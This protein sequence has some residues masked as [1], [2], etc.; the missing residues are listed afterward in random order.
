MARKFVS[1]ST[2]S[3]SVNVAP[4]NN[5]P[6]TI[7]HRFNSQSL[8]ANQN[9]LMVGPSSGSADNIGTGFD[10]ATGQA[11]FY[12]SD[13][14][15]SFDVN[16][17][18]PIIKLNRWYSIVFVGR[19]ASDRSGYIVDHATGVIYALSTTFPATLGGTANRIWLGGF[20]ST[21]GN[22]DAVISD[23]AMWSAALE[24]QEVLAYLKGSRAGSIRRAAL[25]ADWR[26]DGTSSPETDFSG[27]GN[28]LTLNGSPAAAANLNFG[29]VAQRYVYWANAPAA[30]G[31]VGSSTGAATVTGIGAAQDSS[32]GS[33]VGAATVTGVS[34]TLGIGVGSSIGAATVTGVSGAGGSQAVGASV[35]V[36]TVTGIG[37]SI[38][39]SVGS[40]IGQ[41][42]V[43]AYALSKGGGDSTPGGLHAGLMKARISA[44]RIRA[45]RMKR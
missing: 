2:Q 34:Q 32:V 12:T 40:S 13:N 24:N 14:G 22:T 33:S 42:V 37:A 35:G 19:S 11:E 10:T 25:K 38:A 43:A 45:G 7:A 39:A 4:I 5:Y 36:A 41:A 20:E 23:V 8:A 3:L 17:F 29:T 31:S 44:G 30:A 27:G 28:S 26:L 9:W 6:F 18:G 1:A 21:T 15:T 16:K